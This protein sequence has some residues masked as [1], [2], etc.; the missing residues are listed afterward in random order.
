MSKN[1]EVKGGYKIKNSRT[2]N[3]RVFYPTFLPITHCIV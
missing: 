2:D 3:T 1:G